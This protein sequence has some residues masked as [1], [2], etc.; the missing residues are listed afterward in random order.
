MVYL[1]RRLEE[2]GLATY[3]FQP[4]Q[5]R[6]RPGGG[7]IACDDY[8]GP[9][10]LLVRFFPAEW[11]PQLPRHTGW[12]HLAYGAPVCNP[13]HAVLTQSK[14]FPLVWDRLATPLPT[15]R[16]LLPATRAPRRFGPA[17]GGAW[18]LKPALGHEG[19]NVGIPEVT[20]EDAWRRIRRSLLRN[21]RAWAAQRRFT[22][23]A[24]P[25]LEG[26]LYPCL[27]VYVIDGRAAGVYGRVAPRPLIDDR[28]REVVVLLVPPPEED[29]TR[30]AR[31]SA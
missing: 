19:Y 15:W 20:E 28:S 4:N 3:L 16:A 25:T 22:P 7:G 9:L 1:A 24:L 17:G 18:V 21:P 8:T 14:R 29:T 10:D 11:L 6:W 26:P 27:G 30:A 13:V 31:G 23:L 5:L 12:H 2:L